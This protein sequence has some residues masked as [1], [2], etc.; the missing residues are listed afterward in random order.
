MK[1]YFRK[2]GEKWYYTI[3]TGIDPV[4][5]KRT[6]V[7]KGGFKTKK[8]A[9]TAAARVVTE[10]EDQSFVK[11]SNVTFE[12]FAND[13]WLPF[14]RATGVKK[15]SIRQ[16]EYQI[17]SLNRFFAKLPI[18]QITR[19]AYQDA[20]LKMAGSM[21][22]NT[23]IGIHGTAKMIFRK[24]L[25]YQTIKSDPTE[26]AKVLVTEVKTEE[27][28]KYFEKEELNIFLKAAKTHGMYDDYLFY[29]SLA[30]TG[31]RVGE[32]IVLRW[33]DVNFDNNTIS[34]NGTLYN[35]DDLAGWYEIEDPKTKKSKRT[36]EVDES[37]MNQLKQHSATQKIFKMKNRK[38]YHD[39]DLVFGRMDDYFGFPPTL[40]KVNTRLQRIM[41]HTPIN[42]LITPHSFRHTHTS[43]LAEAGVSLEAIMDR[44][45]HKDDKVTRTV[46]L[47]VT[48]TVKKEASQKFSK[49]MANVVKM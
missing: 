45:G 48:K 15:G 33:S 47:H 22:K 38:L 40:C 26:F 7:S 11:E 36:I 13:V 8:D 9:Q 18:K 37:I 2:R 42:S 21:V 29:A 5:G 32:L 49:L 30:Y 25:E 43:L 41:R 35:P 39:G 4:S 44:L 1:G 14:Y 23:I 16:R 17:K 34:V 10:L 27:F 24:A 46:Y 20:L 6:Q 28:P 19:K 12:Q 3:D 31:L